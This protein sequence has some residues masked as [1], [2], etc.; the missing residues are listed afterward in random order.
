MFQRQIF[1]FALTLGFSHCLFA[2]EVAPSTTSSVI[3]TNNS[4]P[5]NSSAYN[6]DQSQKS[7][8]GI[9]YFFIGGQGISQD[10]QYSSFDVFDSYLSFNYKA[11]P[12]LRFA[13]RP[14]FGYA[15][16][17]KNKFGDE[18]TNK[19][20]VRDFSFLMTIYNVGEDFLPATVSYKLQPRLYLPTGDDSKE[21]GMIARLRIENEVRW[22]FQKYS[23]VRF[24]ATPSYFF[25]RSTTYVSNQNPK[26]PN[27]LKTTALMDSEHGVEIGYSVNKYFSIKP[28][29]NFIEKYSN[30]SLINGLTQF[31][32]SVVDYRIG[33]EIRP[34]RQFSFTVGL[35]SEQDL[36]NTDKTNEISYSVLTGGTLF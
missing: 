4:L 36:I 16:E 1:K 21:Q 15:F 22:S 11:A 7:A 26:K 33:I 5:V 12:D 13:A 18:V 10:N 9:T 14:A 17:G 32:S 24:Y 30:E 28:G 29:L 31:H 27:Q 2:A 25:Q 20:R 34:T 23:E 8:F 3:N 19:S 35:Q 6:A